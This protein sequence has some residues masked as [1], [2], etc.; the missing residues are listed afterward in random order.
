MSEEAE[1]T[2]VVHHLQTDCVNTDCDLLFDMTGGMVMSPQ[3]MGF[4]GEEPLYLTPDMG[5]RGGMMM[6]TSPPRMNYF[7]PPSGDSDPF[8]LW[9]FADHNDAQEFENRKGMM[10]RPTWK[11]QQPPCI[12]EV[13]AARASATL[14]GLV[15]RVCLPHL[16]ILDLSS[17][18]CL[19][20]VRPSPSLNSL[21]SPSSYCKPGLPGAL[22]VTPCL[23]S[24]EWLCQNMVIELGNGEQII[25]VKQAAAYLQLDFSSENNY[26]VCSSRALELESW[27]GMI[28]ERISVSHRWRYAFCSKTQPWNMVLEV[29]DVVVSLLLCL[30]TNNYS[31]GISVNDDCSFSSSSVNSK[32]HSLL[33]FERTCLEMQHQN[34]LER[35][36]V[37]HF[38]R[39]VQTG[40]LELLSGEEIKLRYLQ[41]EV[42]T[43]SQKN[44]S[45]SILP[46]LLGAESRM[47]QLDSPCEAHNPK[48]NAT[49]EGR[50][51]VV[52]GLKRTDAIVS[53][54]T[55]KR[56]RRDFGITRH[57]LE[58]VGTASD[59]NH[60]A[61]ICPAVEAQYDAAG[62]EGMLLL[63]Q[64]DSSS[65][66]HIPESSATNEERNNVV[67]ELNNSIDANGGNSSSEK[68]DNISRWEK[69]YGITR[70]LLEQ[71][72]GKN[73]DDAAK[74]LKV[75]ISTLK[76]A[77]R[78]FGINRWPN[79]KGKKPNCS[80]NQNQHVQAVKKHKGIQ[81][82]CPALPPLQ[83]TN[84][85]ECNTTMSV[86]VTYKN[87]TIRLPL[88]SSSTIKYLEEQ[89]ET[90][91]KISLQNMSITYQDEEDEWIT[92][93]C[94][95]GLL[96]GLDV[97]RSCGKT[98][99]RMMVTPKC[100]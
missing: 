83:P 33:Y 79:H 78:D 23:L 21:T 28:M 90:K 59:E 95:S 3:W 100:G 86:K 18:K 89:L 96:H 82:A 2:I 62:R 40:V 57:S 55:F 60:T 91:F 87:D 29:L 15:E 20:D 8:I 52:V 65:E 12:E 71:L 9:N 72:F 37:D 94:D 53:S 88:S 76:R 67:V 6:S 11:Q 35:Q 64:E 26:A 58:E 98:V 92:L 1:T 47:M 97:L 31:F 80:L 45:V 54:S 19:R 56:A 73:R 10:T 61:D 44:H 63:Q 27:G 48:S 5:M 75:S 17:C 32:M 69:D 51:V 34:S 38:E 14:A 24:L 49:N 84:T 66:A 43:A 81:P 42:G 50:N 77:C 70:Q 22:G 85:S 93:M 46:A 30:G 16:F 36:F 39:L 7:S 74:T 25:N 68:T 13:G 41:E 4:S 99:I